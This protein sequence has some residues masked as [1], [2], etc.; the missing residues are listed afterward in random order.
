VA[1]VGR[2]LARPVSSKS[3]YLCGRGVLRIHNAHT[4][5]NLH[6]QR[7]SYTFTIMAEVPDSPNQ[8]SGFSFPKRKFGTTK[9]VER[10]FQGGWFKSW[11]WLHYVE[12][13]DIVF[14]HVCVKALKEKKI[15]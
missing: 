11:P 15:D 8:P 1:R 9:V 13:R 6:G 3:N 10:S 5:V 4:H 7:S 12:E 2:V 14:C